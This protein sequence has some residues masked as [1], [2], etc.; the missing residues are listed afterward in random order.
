MLTF[1]QAVL[2]Y[3][4]RIGRLPDLII[5]QAGVWELASEHFRHLGPENT[6][7]QRLTHPVLKHD[8]L[9]AEWLASWMA[10]V[11]KVM[12]LLKVILLPM[13]AMTNP[14]YHACVLPLPSTSKYNIL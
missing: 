10:N 3:K 8:N 7:P 4:E 12:S 14:G 6:G 13:S 9:P 11:A 5:L 2:L 1:L